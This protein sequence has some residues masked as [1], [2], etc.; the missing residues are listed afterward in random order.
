MYCIHILRYHIYTMYNIIYVILLNPHPALRPIQQLLL[1]YRC[2]HHSVLKGVLNGCTQNDVPASHS[3]GLVNGTR[4]GKRA[5]CTHE[6]G[7]GLE[8][9]RWSWI[10]RRALT[11]V[12]SVLVRGTAWKGHREET[13][14][15]D[16]GGAWRGVAARPGMP[17]ASGHWKL[18]GA[19]NKSSPRAS[20]ENLTLPTP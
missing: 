15:E 16:G 14:C 19:S 10:I 6:K 4:F 7:E 3:L 5:F 1:L 11:P 2:R 12:T 9:R 18:E 13:R 8:L 17:A 20:R